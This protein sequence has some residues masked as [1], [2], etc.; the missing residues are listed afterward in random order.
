MSTSII[1]SR[2]ELDKIISNSHIEDKYGGNQYDEFHKYLYI[3]MYSQL[4]L[5][6]ENRM[7]TD[8]ETGKGISEADYFFMEWLII[9]KSMTK[10]EFESL[11]EDEF[12]SLV[13]EYK[14]FTKTLNPK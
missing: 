9:S 14:D 12:N 10:E 13:K 1:T 7:I 11:T 8:K 5:Y 2:K 3:R 4:H 6:K